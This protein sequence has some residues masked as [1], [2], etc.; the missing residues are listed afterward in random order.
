[1]KRLRV[2]HGWLRLVLLAAMLTAQLWADMPVHA[3]AG[4][5][6]YD[7]KA[8]FVYQFLAYV[9]WPASKPPVGPFVIGVVGANELAGNLAALGAEAGPSA[10]PIE[11]RR[12]SVDD[13]PRDLH[14]LFV[15][16]DRSA[17]A[18]ALISAAA[19]AAVLTVTESLPR[20]ADAM[21]N[22]EIVENRVRFEVALGPV[23]ASGLE[24]SARMLGV[25]LRVVEAP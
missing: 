10:R 4:P 2:P 20:H 18:D 9:T 16:A 17:E 22:F 8:A 23:R 7:L 1:M 25:A 21:I 13:D 12:L 3:Q 14:V 15:A 11:I 5:S 6:E 19:D 24:V